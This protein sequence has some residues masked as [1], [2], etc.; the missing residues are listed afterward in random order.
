MEAIAAHPEVLVILPRQAIEKGFRG[1]G[2]VKAGIKDRHLHDPG[3]S[4]CAEAMPLRLA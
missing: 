4:R 2:L 3:N 1:Q